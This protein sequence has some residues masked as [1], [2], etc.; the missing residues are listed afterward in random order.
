MQIQ[1]LE[2]PDEVVDDIPTSKMAIAFKLAQIPP[3]IWITLSIDAKN[4]IND[5]PIKNQDPV[6]VQDKKYHSTTIPYQYA[7]VKT[8]LEGKEDLRNDVDQNYTF[9]DK[10]LEESVKNSNLYESE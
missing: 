5:Q 6:K 7:R 2:V 1:D 8:T 3:E 9:I 10:F 4:V